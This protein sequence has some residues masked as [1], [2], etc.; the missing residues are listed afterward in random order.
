VLHLAQQ[1]SKD[2]WWHVLLAQTFGQ[3]VKTTIEEKTISMDRISRMLQN[4]G[5]QGGNMAALGHAKNVIDGW[6]GFQIIRTLPVHLLPNTGPERIL[7]AF[8]GIL[9]CAVPHYSGR[10]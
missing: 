10:A 5:P 2:C 1:A 9:S 7:T 3:S 4:A 8:D 6:N